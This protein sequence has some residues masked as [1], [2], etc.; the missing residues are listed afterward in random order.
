MTPPRV[1]DGGAAR[2]GAEDSVTPVPPLLKLA[3]DMRAAGCSIIAV[4]QDKRPWY[5]WAAYQDTPATADQLLRWHADPRTKGYALVCGKVSGGVEVLDFDE[6]DF[7]PAWLATAP[8]WAADLPSQRT[9]GGGWQVAYRR[10][11]DVPGNRK[12]AWLPPCDADGVKRER[13]EIG[14]ETRGQGGYACIPHSLHPS[15]NLYQ[16]MHGDWSALP[17]LLGEWADQLIAAARSLSHEDPE[18][19]R[20]PAP[21][22]AMAYQG[23]A[24]PYWSAA[25]QKELDKLRAGRKGGRNDQLNISACAIGNMVGGGH[26]EESAAVAALADVAREIGL[27]PGEIMPTI[28]SGLD[29]GKMTPRQK[30][31][32]TP[33][34]PRKVKAQ[35]PRLALQTAGKT[36]ASSAGGYGLPSFPHGTQEGTDEANAVIL[37]ANNLQ[38]RLRYTLNQG[39][40]AYDPARGVWMREPILAAA[41]AGEVLRE[42]VGQYF[43]DLLKQHA[44]KEDLERVGRWAT[45]V[46]NVGTVTR[47]LTAAAGKPEFLTP[48]DAWN[49]RPELL[50]CPNGTLELT[51]GTLRPHDPADLMT[52]QAGAAYDPAAQHPYVERLLELLRADGR[53]DL[54]QRW[55]GSTL[56]GRAPNE[57]FVVL[58][59]PGGTGKGTLAD[60]LKATLGE[61]AHTI[62]VGLILHNAHGDSGTGPKPELLK[63]QGKRLVIASE[64][65]EHAR[66]NAGRVKGMT[67]ND[68]ITARWM[69]SN[70]MVTFTPVF[71]LAI[72]TNHPIKSSHDDSGLQ[73][74]II[75]VPFSARPAEADGN[76]K[77]TLRTDPVALSAFLNWLVEGCRLWLNSGYDLGESAVVQAATAG[78]WKDQNPYE[79]FAAARLMFGDGLEITSG[80]LKVMFEEWVAE[81]AIRSRE[82]KLADLH[83]FLRSAGC[84][85]YRTKLERGWDGVSEAGDSGD[86]GDTDSPVSRNLLHAYTENRGTGVTSVT[87]VTEAWAQEDL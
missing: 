15:G 4:G 1:Q 84:K 65:D 77:D 37:A 61:Y 21:A 8:D 19:S 70:D 47:A 11:G 67:G 40:Y 26:I 38:G 81:N 20:N 66:F 6:P 51:S 52:C 79:R 48:V 23:G 60:T 33:K 57:K 17:S 53:H 13:R 30:P 12:L 29:K 41:V 75:V 36:P 83:A 14:I 44:D 71:K 39:W 25:F 10:S 59:G 55:A 73:R 85:P 3:L 42:V 16:P 49:A 2:A 62:E 32:G 76:F 58:S 35:V 78:Y 50:N 82:A 54:L 56:Y 22:A 9:G 46:C 72:Q 74:R 86:G 28:R 24:A 68:P 5:K 27:D 69:H 7:Y 45:N 34:T 43:L 31:E 80:R 64:P 18:E 63:L 87:S